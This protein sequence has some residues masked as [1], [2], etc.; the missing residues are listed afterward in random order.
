MRDSGAHW[1]ALWRL[2]S[3]FERCVDACARL[4]AYRVVSPGVGDDHEGV[5]ALN[6]TLDALR[7]TLD[8]E[9]SRVTCERLDADLQ[10]RLSRRPY[11]QTERRR[12]VRQRPRR[13]SSRAT[14]DPP[15]TA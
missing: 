14:W 10:A 9:V 8:A 7:A 12:R 11:F 5:A 2:C 3:T 6:R 4:D 13:A 15:S 1:I